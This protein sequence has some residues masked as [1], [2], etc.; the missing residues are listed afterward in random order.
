MNTEDTTLTEL[1]TIV[2]DTL[3]HEGIIATLS[4]VAVVSIYTE[5]R[6]VSEDMDFVTIALVKQLTAALESL[7][8]KRTG[9]PRPSVFEHP[10]TT[11]VP[12]V[13]TGS[14]E[15]WWHLR[16]SVKVCADRNRLG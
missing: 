6:Y 10:S 15:L 3:E 9:Q 8:F 4:G 13:P 7:G 5:G 1:A 2:S 14:T 12:R 11:M 16:R